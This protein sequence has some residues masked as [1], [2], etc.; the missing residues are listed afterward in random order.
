MGNLRIRAG[1][2]HFCRYSDAWSSANGANWTEATQGLLPPG[3]LQLGYSGD[4]WSSGDGANWNIELPWS[5]L[6]E[7]WACTLSM[8]GQLW[9]IATGSSHSTIRRRM[10]VIGGN[11]ALSSRGDIWS[12]MDGGGLA[13]EL[14]QEHCLTLR[15]IN[16]GLIRRPLIANDLGLEVSTA[17]RSARKRIFVV[18]P[19]YHCAPDDARKR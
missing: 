2:S 15:D 19:L 17:P 11:D 10:L 4:V 16:S 14:H 5:T 9:V 18:L 12:S 8:N 13:V 3:R 6:I 1:R 7:G